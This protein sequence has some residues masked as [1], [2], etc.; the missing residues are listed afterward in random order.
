VLHLDAS[1]RRSERLELACSLAACFD[2]HLVG[3]FALAELRVRGARGLPAALLRRGNHPHRRPAGA[4]RALRRALLELASPV[5][6]GDLIAAG[7]E[8][9]IS[10]PVGGDLV[11]A[12]GSLRLEGATAQN[13]YAA[14]G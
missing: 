4:D 10:A 5:L 11:A 14:G 6:K 13:L 7:G 2:A 1:A 3:L 9:R 12:G 8:V